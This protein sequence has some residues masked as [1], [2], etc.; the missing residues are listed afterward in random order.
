M[1]TTSRRTATS[2]GRTAVLAD[3]RGFFARN[4]LCRSR[5]ERV[6][7]GV[8]AALGRRVQLRPWPARLLFLLVLMLLPGSQ[9][10]VYPIL[11]VLLPLEQAPTTTVIGW[12]SVAG[13]AE[14]PR[15]ATT[16]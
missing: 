14:D 1:T 15:S 11:W 12:G 7:G 2:E 16:A 9:L 8:C 4:G 10:I 6:L 5:D 13:P 3:A